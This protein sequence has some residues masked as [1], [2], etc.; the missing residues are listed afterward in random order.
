MDNSNSDEDTDADFDTQLIIQQSLLDI[1]KPG[2]T[3]HTSEDKR[4]HSILSA[5]HKKIAEAIETVRKMHW[6]I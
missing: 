4:S 5:D 2:V 1:Y 3:Q 6:H